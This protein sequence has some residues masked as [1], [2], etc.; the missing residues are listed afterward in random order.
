M[1]RS[2]KYVDKYLVAS[3]ERTSEP[4]DRA[5]LFF[6][7]ENGQ[8]LFYPRLR[9]NFFSRAKRSKTSREINNREKA[10]EQTFEVGEKNKNKPARAFVKTRLAASVSV[11]RAGIDK[12]GAIGGKKKLRSCF[13]ECA[14]IAVHLG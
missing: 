13:D 10:R 5:L 2:R 11:L 12:D 8:R 4:T 3:R 6:S 1:I 7:Q 14:V 9:A